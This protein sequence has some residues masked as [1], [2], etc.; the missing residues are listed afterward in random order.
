ME[1][2]YGMPAILTLTVSAYTASHTNQ[3]TG[4]RIHAVQ[5]IQIPSTTNRNFENGSSSTAPASA[6]DATFVVP[7]T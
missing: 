2:L 7:T 6:G 3:H 5:H 1:H 4:V